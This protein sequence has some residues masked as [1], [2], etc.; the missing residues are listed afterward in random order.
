MASTFTKLT[1]LIKLSISVLLAS[2]SCVWILK[3]TQLWK[4]SWHK[5]EDWADSTF[6]REPGA[7][8]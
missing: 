6:I 2:V 3:P 1:L 4:R 8:S 5:A 7:A